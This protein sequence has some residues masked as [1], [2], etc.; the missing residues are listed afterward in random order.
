M[1]TFVDTMKPEG[2][3]DTVLRPSYWGGSLNPA[4]SVPADPAVQVAS[5][6]REIRLPPG[7]NKAQFER[8][9]DDL[10]GLIGAENVELNDVP[11]NDGSY[12]HVAKSHD[13]YAVMERDYFVASAVCYPGSTAEVQAV[14]RWANQWLIPLWPISI[15]RN[16]ICS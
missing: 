9:M 15:G 14:V 2:R 1:T 12:Y 10:R 6:K 16:V 13:S 4:L 8:A 3:P 5:G 11:L 7:M